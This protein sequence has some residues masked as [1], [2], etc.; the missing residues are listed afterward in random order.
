MSCF[1]QIFSARR[2]VYA[3][4]L[5]ACVASAETTESDKILLII[6]IITTA[7][8]TNNYDGDDSDYNNNR[9]VLL[10]PPMSQSL[11]DITTIESGTFLSD[12]VD[13]LMLII[14]SFRV[15]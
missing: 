12:L 14:V 15:S 10:V 5:S 11:S 3:N 7:A 1:S 9:K 13:F 6:M 4:C 8:A 2:R